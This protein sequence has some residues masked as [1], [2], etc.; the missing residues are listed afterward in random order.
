MI[1]FLQMD[2]IQL[3]IIVIIAVITGLFLTFTIIVTTKKVQNKKKETAAQNEKSLKI[4]DDDFF[5][6]IGGVDNVISYKLVG[7]RLTLELKD[8]TKVDKEG[9]KK[10]KFDGIVE[11]KNKMILV[12]EDLS[13]ELKALDNLKLQ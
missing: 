5:K 12:K 1:N 7:S 11:M 10:E 13:K 4:S 9:L 6:L 3:S 2:P 8:Y